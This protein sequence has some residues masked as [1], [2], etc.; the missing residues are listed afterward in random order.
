MQKGH[1]RVLMLACIDFPLAF[2]A[3]PTWPAAASGDGPALS[4]PRRRAGHV[5]G[6]RRY[7]GAA[8]GGSEGGGGRLDARFRSSPALVRRLGCD[9]HWGDDVIVGSPARRDGAAARWCG[10]RVRPCWPSRGLRLAQRPCG[11]KRGSGATLRI[12]VGPSLPPAF[13]TPLSRPCGHFLF[14]FYRGCRA[15][16][17]RTSSPLSNLPRASQRL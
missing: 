7:P 10:A 11:E 4:R 3:V 12:A 14:L 13:L 9:T 5:A 2:R 6:G 15:L 16:L 8:L 17:L 1:G